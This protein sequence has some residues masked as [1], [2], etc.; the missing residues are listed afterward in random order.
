M[1]DTAIYSGDILLSENLNKEKCEDILIYD[2][3][4]KSFMGLKSLH[5]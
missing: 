1:R 3:S 5:I 4:Y 2:I